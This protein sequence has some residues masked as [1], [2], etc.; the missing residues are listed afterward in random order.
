[1]YKTN[2]LKT[3]EL[4]TEIIKLIESTQSYC[5]IVSPYI[6]IWP[7]L[8]RVLSMAASKKTFLT[9]VI[10]ED[11]GSDKLI[12]LL[13]GKYG[14]EVYVI[15]DLHIKLYL[16]ESSCLLSTMNLYDAS[17][18]KNLELGY[19]VSNAAEVKKKI[20]DDYISLT[21]RLNGIKEVL[22]KCESLS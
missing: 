3:H 2:F 14:F 11:K 19:F 7:Q 18:Q 1:M 6:K 12:E 15:A 16:N 13:N 20:I 10:R 21:F 4:T 8:E 9:F 5:Y 17:Q 22:K